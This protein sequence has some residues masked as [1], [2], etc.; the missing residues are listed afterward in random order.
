MPPGA[1]GGEPVA[2]GRFRTFVPGNFARPQAS[3]RGMTSRFPSLRP[4][5]GL[6]FAVGLLA[7][8][9]SNDEFRPI[10]QTGA[11][12]S[13]RALPVPELA[14]DGKFFDGQIETE[15]QLGRAPF[16]PRVS[17]NSDADAGAGRGAGPGGFR[18]GFGGGRRGGRGMGRG[19]GGAPA[20]G[21]DT[22]DAGEGPNRP[23]TAGVARSSQEPPIRFQLRVT[24]HGAEPAEVEV[25]DFDST[26]G[27]F[28]VQPRKLTLAPGESVEV[29]PM[30]SRLGVPGGEMPVT[31]GVRVN[32]KTE[33]ET[34]TLKAKDPA[35]PA[36]AGA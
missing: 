24:N 33:K 4:A 28:V 17:A 13:A 18:G 8:C 6:V 11:R 25:T 26:L 3:D 27:N 21:G 34:I 2:P 19:M 22:G 12:Q 9:S 20:G 23:G 16:A 30:T 15:V 5:L 14:G 35:A 36:A 32:G 29:D 10:R 7:G 1:A 31:V